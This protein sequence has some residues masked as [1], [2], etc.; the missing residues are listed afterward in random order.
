MKTIF[1][2]SLIV[3]MFCFS[4]FVRA[5]GDEGG[6][7]SNHD[8]MNTDVDY[9]VTDTLSTGDTFKVVFAGRDQGSYMDHVTFESIAFD[10]HYLNASS[11]T[12]GYYSVSGG[13]LTLDS[14]SSGIQIAISGSRENNFH[15][16]IGDTNGQSIEM[17]DASAILSGGQSYKIDDAKFDDLGGDL[18]EHNFTIKKN[19]SSFHIT[20]DVHYTET[21]TT[22]GSQITTT[23]ALTASTSSAVTTIIPEPHIMMLMIS[24]LVI[25]R[26]RAQRI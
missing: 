25:L 5:D 2:I 7:E 16:L 23:T 3:F 6:H 24:G 14:G 26:L 13:R 1:K 11:V 15:I 17:S 12:L 18:I 22:T 21:D 9:A 20:N 8:D 4:A 19:L 10:G